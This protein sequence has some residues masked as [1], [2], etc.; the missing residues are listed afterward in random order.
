MKKKIIW[1]TFPSPGASGVKWLNL[2][3]GHKNRECF[4]KF[5]EAVDRRLLSTLQ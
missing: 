3:E 4:P 5:Y 1:R 2:R